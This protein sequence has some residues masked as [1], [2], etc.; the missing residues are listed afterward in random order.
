[1]N[2][3][4]TNDMYRYVL[5]ESEVDKYFCNINSINVYIICNSYD[6]RKNVILI[7]IISFLITYLGKYTPYIREIKCQCGESFYLYHS[8]RNVYAAGESEGKAVL[9]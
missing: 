8:P 4:L 7:R 5:R 2:L 6:S 9:I 3:T 1:M